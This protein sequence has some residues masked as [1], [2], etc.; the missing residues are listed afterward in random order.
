MFCLCLPT[1]NLSSP[2]VSISGFV[3]F[4]LFS[5]HFLY[6]SPLPSSYLQRLQQTKIPQHFKET[7]FFRPSNPQILIEAQNFQ[8]PKFSKILKNSQKFSLT[9]LRIFLKTILAAER[10]TLRKKFSKKILKNSQKTSKILKDK[11][12]AQKIQNSQ[13]SQ[14]FSKILIDIFEN[15]SQ[16]D[17]GC[18]KNNFEKKILKKNS[19]KFSKNLK[20]SQ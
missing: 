2:S 1:F 18:R 8:N 9:F 17:P 14:K 11:N 12:L 16:N 3:P 6:P 20:N 4:L 19:Q 13:N 10:T 7:I 15:F 5:P